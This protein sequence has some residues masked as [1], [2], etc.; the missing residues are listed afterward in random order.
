MKHKTQVIAEKSL[1]KSKN[2]YKMHDVQVAMINKNRP[3]RRKDADHSNIPVHNGHVW[4]WV[5]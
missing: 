3:G 1:P 2:R 4:H 5:I